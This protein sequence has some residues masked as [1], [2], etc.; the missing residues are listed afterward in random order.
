M[1]IAGGKILAGLSAVCLSTV[2]MA[3]GITHEYNSVGGGKFGGNGAKYNSIQGQYTTG[4]QDFKWVVDYADQA[5]DGGWLVISDGPNPKIADDDLAILYFDDATM[6]VWAYAYNGKNNKA[7]YKETDFLGYFEDAYTRVG[8]VATLMLNAAGI[9]SQISTGLRFGPMIGIWFHPAYDSY[10][11]GDKTGLYEF[12]GGKSGWYDTH[13]DG[14]KCEVVQG[15]RGGCVTTTVPEPGTL[16]LLGAGL[17]GLGL[18]RRRK[19]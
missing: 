14:G 13:Y 1:K 8:N 12:G 10:A 4:S 11:E 6:D 3:G 18:R 2:A 19:I 15:G 17:L 16:A 5:A 7:S 9:N